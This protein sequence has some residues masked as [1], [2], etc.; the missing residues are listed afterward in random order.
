MVAAGSLSGA[1][2]PLSRRTCLAKSQKI[3]ARALLPL[4]FVGITRST[5]ANSLSVLH[6]ATI[7]MPTSEASFTACASALGSET[8]MTSG[9]IRFGYSG[10]ESIPGMNLPTRGVAPVTWQNFLTG[11]CAYSLLAA[12]VTLACSKRERN[13]AATLIRSSVFLTSKTNNPSGLTR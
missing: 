3:T 1:S 13:F 7:G 9:S 12:A 2:S 6:K 11:S 10:F 5:P 8:I 4:L